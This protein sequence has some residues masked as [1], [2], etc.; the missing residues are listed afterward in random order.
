MIGFANPRLQNQNLRAE[1]EEAIGRVFDSGQFILGE[2]VAAFERDFA[3]YCGVPHA[4]AVNSGTSALHL[5][6]LAAG[7]GPGDEV[8]TTAF[9][10]IATVAA[11][12]YIQ[13]VPVLV[14][15]DPATFTIDPC[16][17]ES[18]ITSKTRAI[19]PV[20]LYGHPADMD[21]I[22][23]IARRHGLTVIEDA[24]QA[25]GARYRSHPVG[26]SG[27]AA[28][29]S[30]YP[31]KNLGACGE[32][33]MVV[34]GDDRIAAAVRR[35]RSWG[36][37]ANGQFD[38]QGFNY[39]MDGIQGAVLGVKLKYLDRWVERRQAI[40]ARYHS[41]L[42]ESAVK[43]MPWAH[44]AYHIYALRVSDRESVRA[45]FRAQGV[46]TAVHYPYPVHGMRGW[47]CGGYTMGDFPEAERAARETLSIPV[48]SELSAI[49]VD[50]I[51]CALG[52]VCENN[53]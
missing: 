3:A 15:I 36:I 23:D 39:R 18:A 43:V 29:F 8:I 48:H 2:H 34:T 37:D 19:I 32:G 14:D 1:L 44:H 11:I 51:S 45:C 21:A 10:F 20:H 22:M 27:H 7:V 13:A 40:A 50:T 9:T 46:E 38:G 4:I 52:E 49:E 5:T 26:V 28:C 17:I 47:R 42:R 25:H 12:H 30:F 53:R 33:G 35:W 16:R 41:V 24:A 31:T 6:L